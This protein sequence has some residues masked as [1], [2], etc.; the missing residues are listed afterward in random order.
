MSRT[1]RSLLLAL[2]QRAFNEKYRPLLRC[3]SRYVICYGGAGSGKSYFLAQRYVLR[4]L[5][6]PMCNVL[7]VRQVQRT[8]RDSTFALLRQVIR[9][10]KLG[11]YFRVAEGDMRVV[12]TLNG[13]SVIFAG[14][15][16]AEKLKSV[17]F[18]RGEL[19]DIW[20]EEA[21]QVSER[22]FNQLDIRLRGGHSE[23]QICISFNPISANHW[24]KRRFFD[25]RC[26]N[27]TVVHSTYRDNRFLDADY[28][29]LLESYRTT[30]PYYYDV[31]CLGQWGVYGR[32]VFDA[33]AVNRRLAAAP[34]D[35][36]RGRFVFNWRYDAECGE[37]QPDADSVR[38]VE[39]GAGEI[40]IYR[41]PEPGVPYV[42]GADTAGEGSDFFAAQV[43]D[44]RTGAQAAVLHSAYDEDVFAHQIFCLGVYYNRALVGIEANFSTYPIRELARCGYT[45]QYVREV[46][47]AFTH[48]M[49]QSYG[50]RTTAVTR[51]VML[52]N[53]V[54]VVRDEPDTLCDRSTLNELLT[55]VRNEKGRA[56]AQANAH[57]D[58]VMALAIAHYIR[59]QQT[60]AAV[61]PPKP[62]PALPP[63]LADDAH[64]AGNGVMNW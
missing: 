36:T 17:T 54:R 64:A 33:H 27:A 31:Y 18:P 45:H 6:R 13:N 49:K 26:P 40:V 3:R 56:E 2:P 30:D 23:K 14:M 1:A 4:L 24:L 63:E 8:N 29:A 44:H 20:V 61:P 39:D 43:L 9:R 50:V 58:L 5:E 38:F 19:T 52:A 11:D 59:P 57:D 46:E 48:R 62:L 51:P 22:D 25:R 21:S 12:C 7:V 32:T 41:A 53:L 37:K 60:D 15:D 10:W 47:D 35:G 16:D 34:S 42:I 28:C 55:F